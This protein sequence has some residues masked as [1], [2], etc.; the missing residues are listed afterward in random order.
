[1]TS[2]A[3][4][5]VPCASRKREAIDAQ[6][7]ASALPRASQ[8]KVIREWLSRLSAATPRGQAGQLY[9]GRGFALAAEA[10]SSLRVPAFVI[11][12]GLGLVDSQTV[13]PS[14][15]LTVSSGSD[16]WIGARS[17]TPLD[18]AAWWQCVKAGPFS[19]DWEQVLARPGRILVA[20]SRPY[21]EMVGSDLAAFAEADRQRLRIFGQSLAAVLPPALHDQIMPYDARLEALL[22]GTRTDFAQRA[23]LHF[24]RMNSRGDFVGDAAAVRRALAG[25]QAPER[26]NRPRAGNDQI[27]AAIRRHLA[28][29]EGVQAILRLLRDQDRI[30]CEQKRFTR[31]YHLAKAGA[32]AA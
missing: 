23:L 22:P 32:E 10:E 6:L 13:V 31:L 26:I 1:V 30:A 29:T 2:I 24:V 3:A 14:Y 20:L 16:D 18:R 11:S 8:G 15:S 17:T 12:A 27:V 21:A 4:I 9:G 5:I 7:K 25:L 19:S 28:R